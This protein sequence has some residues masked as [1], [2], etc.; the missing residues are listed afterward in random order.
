[1]SENRQESPVQV[2]GYRKVRQGYV[3]SDKGDKTIT[4]LVE[5]RVKHP[6][7]GKVMRR[8]SKVRVH[9]AETRPAWAT[10]SGSPRPVRFPPPSAGAW[11]R[12]WRRP[13]RPD[14]TRGVLT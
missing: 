7:Y 8:S 13:S 2:R 5:D 12:F 14:P 3:V 9:D 11:L 6:L 1:M 10:S 4:V